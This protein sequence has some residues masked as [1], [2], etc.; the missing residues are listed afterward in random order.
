M[1]RRA[2]NSGKPQNSA[3][4]APHCGIDVPSA[5]FTQRSQPPQED[6]RGIARNSPPQEEDSRGAARDSSRST[7]RHSRVQQ[8][9]RQ[10]GA[11]I[12]AIG[13]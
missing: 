8:T 12:V 6:S 7:Y 4:G 1:K 13:I 5:S 3:I 10:D 9:A 2:T 11:D